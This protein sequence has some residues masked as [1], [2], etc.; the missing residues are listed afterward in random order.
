MHLLVL[1]VTL[2]YGY[3]TEKAKKIFLIPTIPIRSESKNQ[4]PNVK[5]LASSVSKNGYFLFETNRGIVT[6][7]Y[8]HTDMTHLRKRLKNDS[9]PLFFCGHIYNVVVSPEAIEG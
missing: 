2:R 5:D 8:K 6:I 1:F 3:A 4:I 9:D 7:T